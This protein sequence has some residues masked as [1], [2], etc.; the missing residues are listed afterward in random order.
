M[1][2]LYLST[3]LASFYALGIPHNEPDINRTEFVTGK[4]CHC[5]ADCDQTMYF[6]VNKKE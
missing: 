5:L 6:Q 1:L 2:I 3:C 4:S